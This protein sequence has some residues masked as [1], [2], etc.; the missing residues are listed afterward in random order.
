MST[1][2]SGELFRYLNVLSRYAVGSIGCFTAASGRLGQTLCLSGWIKQPEFNRLD[3]YIIQRYN[4]NVYSFNMSRNFRMAGGTSR[5]IGCWQVGSVKRVAHPRGY[6]DPAHASSPHTMYSISVGY[7]VSRHSQQAR[8]VRQVVHQCWIEPAIPC[9]N[10]RNLL[11]PRAKHLLVNCNKLR[12]AQGV[13]NYQT[14][15]ITWRIDWS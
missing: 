6:R 13:F 8:Y 4:L 3:E 14:K 5:Q 9:S 7:A 10:G 12:R 11:S 15:P 2:S 1:K